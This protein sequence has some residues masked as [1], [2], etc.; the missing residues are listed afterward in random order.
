MNELPTLY[1]NWMQPR[2]QAQVGGIT[3][4]LTLSEEQ[5][6][7]RRRLA[8]VKG[9]SST[10]N[11]EPFTVSTRDRALS[12]QALPFLPSYFYLHLSDILLAS[13]ATQAC[14][15]AIHNAVSNV[16]KIEAAE[17]GCESSTVST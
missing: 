2:D 17:R 13:T 5:L 1:D 4:A 3:E 8:R 9:S 10:R 11:C 7:L 14:K 12:K 16:V 6:S 15:I